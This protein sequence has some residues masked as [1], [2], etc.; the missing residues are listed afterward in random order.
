MIQGLFGLC[1]VLTFLQLSFWPEFFKSWINHYPWIA[2]FAFLT[3]IV[4]ITKFSIVIGSPDNLIFH[5]MGA[6]SHLV[7]EHRCPIWPFCNW[8]S[9][10]FT[11]LI[12]YFD[13][14]LCNV[15]YSFHTKRHKI[16]FISGT[17]LHFLEKKKQTN[18]NQNS[19][20]QSRSSQG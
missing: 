13:R 14:F 16:G 11:R 15:C 19:G 18:L 4:S 6:R 7:F 1:K 2:W 20:L 17:C 12:R 9:M 5:V 10:W 3:L 8:M